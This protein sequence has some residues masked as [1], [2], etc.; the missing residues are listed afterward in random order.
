MKR[1]WQ[2][3]D[4]ID[5]YVSDAMESDEKI[6]FEKMLSENEALNKRVKNELLIKLNIKRYHR[7]KVKEQLQKIHDKT[8]N[9]KS[10]KLIYLIS[11][12]A[13]VL[14]LLIG[15]F[16]L[17]DRNSYTSQELFAQYYSKFEIESDQRSVGE[18]ELNEIINLYNNDSFGSIVDQSDT[19][20]LSKTPS[21]YR[22]IL[23]ISY[24][25]LNNSEKAKP[26]FQS[27]IDENDII[28]NDQALWYQALAELK[29][30]NIEAAK[31]LLQR[32][33]DDKSS[34]NHENAK[35]LLESL[36]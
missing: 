18:A 12:A 9:K 33:A 1:D 29:S 3:E 19:Y 20:A 31:L 27:I 14:I 10:H 35:S 17:T 13:A 16:Y 4:Q 26:I 8:I 2:I 36:H 30:D 7:S 11:S 32:L 6:A 23:G 22:L 34:D 15:F 28:F 5:K 24:L 25:E 21:S